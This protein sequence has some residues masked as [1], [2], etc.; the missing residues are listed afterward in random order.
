MDEEEDLYCVSFGSNHYFVKKHV[1]VFLMTVVKA[2]TNVNQKM[3]VLYNNMFK[4]NVVLTFVK[5]ELQ[6]AQGKNFYGDGGSFN[7]LISDIKAYFKEYEHDV[8]NVKLDLESE[9]VISI[10][11]EDYEH[12]FI[13]TSV[14][15]VF[16]VFYVYKTGTSYKPEIASSLNVENI[17]DGIDYYLINGKHVISER[18]VGGKI[19]F[20]ED[21]SDKLTSFIRANFENG[22]DDGYR[23]EEYKDLSDVGVQED[24][25]FKKME[26][27][28]FYLLLRNVS[29][30]VLTMVSDVGEFLRRANHYLQEEDPVV[31]TSL[32]LFEMIFACFG[33]NRVLKHL[34]DKMNI[35]DM[36]ILSVNVKI[37]EFKV[38]SIKEIARSLVKP[39]NYLAVYF[40]VLVLNNQSD[41]INT[42]V[43][44]TFR[45]ISEN[46]TKLMKRKVKSSD[47]INICATFDQDLIDYENFVKENKFDQAKAIYNK[48]KHHNGFVD[49]AHDIN[50]KHI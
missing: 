19:S 3:I 35:T 16:G 42:I 43:K 8:E 18:V 31:F 2:L 15:Y 12:V 11:H 27:Q 45:N 39:S 28:K 20:K 5:D 37:E 6:K 22:T 7:S 40:V 33:A 41:E 14:M 25:E 32:A 29:N 30:D 17:Y 34:S 4:Q 38:Q 48:N 9:N 49:N 50:L 26:N 44:N 36:V 10:L 13:H 46:V 23:F 21:I 47:K 24:S 1:K